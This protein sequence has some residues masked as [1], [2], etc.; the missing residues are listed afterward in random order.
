MTEA[1]PHVPETKHL[2]RDQ[3]Q[4]RLLNPLDRRAF[5]LGIPPPG[6]ALLETIG[7][8]TGKPRLTPVCDG[9]AGDTFWIIAQHGRDSAGYATSRLIHASASTPDS[10]GVPEQPTSSA[11]TIRRNVDKFSARTAAGAPSASAPRTR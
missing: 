3:L 6:D 4:K 7:R 11:P 8:R 10:G 1:N 5:Q 2:V 9:L